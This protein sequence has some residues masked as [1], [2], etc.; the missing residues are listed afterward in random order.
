MTYPLE[1]QN[2]GEDE[3]ILMSKGHHDPHH[4][5]R[6]VRDAGYDWPLGMPRHVWMRAV[7]TRIP[8]Y[9]CMYHEVLP[10][11]RGAFPATVA[12]ECY[13]EGMYVPPEQQNLP[14]P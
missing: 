10:H 8:G 13:G 4:F 3:Y 14:Q 9:R 5:M 1:I 7:P 11:A 12:W 2:V 6:A